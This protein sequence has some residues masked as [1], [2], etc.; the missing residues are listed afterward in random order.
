MSPLHRFQQSFWCT[1][2]RLLLFTILE[3]IGCPLKL[4]SLI[5]FLYTNVKPDSSSMVNCRVLKVVS[6]KLAIVS[7]TGPGLQTLPTSYL[8]FRIRIN[9]KKLNC[10][11]C[12][13]NI[14]S[15][16]FVSTDCTL[17]RKSQHSFKQHLVLTGGWNNV[18]SIIVISPRQQN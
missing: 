4:S 11:F 9:A 16:R 7:N 12:R 13:Q 5:K 3:K 1:V 15:F 14:F 10:L 8:R 18:Y 6:N 17:K 2:N